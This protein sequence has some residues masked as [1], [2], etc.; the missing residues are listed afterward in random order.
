MKNQVTVEI[1]AGSLQGEKFI[2]DKIITI[3]AGRNPDCYIQLPQEDTTVSRYHCLLD[4]DPCTHPFIKIRDYGS[5]AGTY[6]NGQKIGQRQPQHSPEEIP[7]TDYPLHALKTGDEIRIGKTTLRVSIEFVSDDSDLNLPIIHA[8]PERAFLDSPPH[9]PN[10]KI[11]KK[12]GQGGFG[13]VYL[14][15]HELTQKS[16]AVKI[17]RPSKQVNEKACKKFMREIRVSQYFTHPHI[18]PVLDTGEVEN[19]LFLVLEYC[20]YG[21][22]NDLLKQYNN[23]LPLKLALQIIDQTLTGLDY[24]H[25]LELSPKQLPDGSVKLITGIVHRDLK[26]GNILC[27]QIDETVTIKIADFGLAKAFDLAGL[28][29]HDYTPDGSSSETP[30]VSGTYGFMCRQQVLDFKYAKPEVD[31]WAAAA[32]LY[33]M[34]TGRLP[35]DFSRSSGLNF[36]KIVLDTPTEPIRR[37]NALIPNPLAEVIDSALKDTSNLYFKTAREFQVALHQASLSIGT[38]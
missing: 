17:I 12:L 13:I 38:Q 33:Q 28:S 1:I 26:P 36:W 23:R 9:I 4:I 21:T 15:E 25:N 18:V 7:Q 10:Y 35:R 5:Y 24:A 6:L 22:V 34:L 29:S 2:F 11:G 30:S 27:S 31:V 37:Y 14:A 16:V 19:S 3:L 32:C 20:P 8:S